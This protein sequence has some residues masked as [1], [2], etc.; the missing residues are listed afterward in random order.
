MSSRCDQS[1][2]VSSDE[3]LVLTAFV[4]EPLTAEPVIPLLIPLMRRVSESAGMAADGAAIDESTSLLGAE[5]SGKGEEA[6]GASSTTDDEGSTGSATSG[7][8]SGT[9]PE[10]VRERLDSTTVGRPE[11]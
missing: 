8:I 9:S 4:A 10:C 7:C 11:G 1:R 6:T 2:L 5:A 3:A